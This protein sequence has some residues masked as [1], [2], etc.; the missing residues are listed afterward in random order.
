MNI[1]LIGDSIRMGYQPLVSKLLKGKATV[2][3]PG[4]NCRHSLCILDNFQGWI[5]DRKPDILHINCGLHDAAEDVFPDGKAQVLI[6]QYGINLRRIVQKTKQFLPET[7]MIWAMTTPRFLY[8]YEP[9]NLPFYQWKPK[10]NI[11]QYNTCARK[12]MQAN[13]ILVNDLHKVVLEN[14]VKKCMRSEDGL[15]MTTFGNEVLADA[16]TGIVVSIINKN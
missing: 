16:V 5:I 2:W 11:A 9:R 15:H 12:I 14:D 8:A 6:S 3:G 4:D 10:K 7:T 13:N 1:V